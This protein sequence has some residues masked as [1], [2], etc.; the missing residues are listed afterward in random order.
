MA[1]AG[2]KRTVSGFA[3]ALLMSAGAVVGVGSPAAASD[4]NCAPASAPPKTTTW[5]DDDLKFQGTIVAHREVI[6]PRAYYSAVYDTYGPAHRQVEVWRGVYGHTPHIRISCE[7][8]PE[9][10][11]QTTD[12]PIVTGLGG[13]QVRIEFPRLRS[14][15]HMPGSTPPKGKVEVGP[16]E[17][18]E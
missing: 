15:L 8:K 14:V 7:R 4:G 9:L 1:R 5:Y 18:V 2:L 16:V 10:P 3:V 12:T 17:Q 11:Q 13:G 6:V